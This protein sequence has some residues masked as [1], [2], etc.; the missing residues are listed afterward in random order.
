M[1]APFIIPLISGGAAFFVGKKVEESAGEHKLDLLKKLADL[2][3]EQAAAVDVVKKEPVSTL[4]Q[5]VALGIGPFKPLPEA[6]SERAKEVHAENLDKKLQKLT[7]DQQS[8]VMARAT[9]MTPG[10]EREIAESPDKD[11]AVEKVVEK[12][13]KEA[14]TL[15]TQM[16]LANEA[17][18]HLPEFYENDVLY[19][20]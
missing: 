9:E 3:P 19:K 15:A 10:D 5:R 12:K 6:A 11:A 16:V 14:D 17:V 1:V 18:T 20:G 13:M 4:E 7:P 2:T 8:L